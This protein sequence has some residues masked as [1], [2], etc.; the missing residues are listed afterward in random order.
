[1]RGP[2]SGTATRQGAATCSP[3]RPRGLE[4]M[5]R[6]VAAIVGAVD[7]ASSPVVQIGRARERPPE[8]DRL[9]VLPMLL[10]GS[11]GVRLRAQRA[12]LGE[13]EL[14]LADQDSEVARPEQ[15]L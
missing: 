4:L 10:P 14:T 7:D 11:T 8:N 15:R 5:D 12:D 6:H 3:R 9:E 13:A 1:M 2:T